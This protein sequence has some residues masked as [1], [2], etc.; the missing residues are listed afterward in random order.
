[1]LLDFLHILAVF[2]L[3]SVSCFPRL[4]TDDSSSNLY[5]EALIA[6]DL[7]EV[8]TAVDAHAL[9]ESLDIGLFLS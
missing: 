4:S 8:G 6:K 5:L 7:L 3:R 9:S 1:L 2:G